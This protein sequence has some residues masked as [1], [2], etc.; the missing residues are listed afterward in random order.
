MTLKTLETWREFSY[1]MSDRL[2]TARIWPPGSMSMPG[3][4]NKGL[5]VESNSC[6]CEQKKSPPPD[7]NKTEGGSKSTQ[8]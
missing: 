5:R 6:L 1:F 7:V 4:V 8:S 2:K 3:L